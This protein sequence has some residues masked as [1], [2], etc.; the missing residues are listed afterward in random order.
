MGLCKSNCAGKQP[1]PELSRDRKGADTKVRKL[2][3][4]EA[5]L[6]LDFQSNPD[7]EGGDTASDHLTILDPLRP[8]GGA[9]D[10]LNLLALPR[11]LPSHQAMAAI[12]P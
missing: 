6:S 9:S 5:K 4:D 1:R 12:D 11:K 2:D 10:F 3:H 8:R 7:R